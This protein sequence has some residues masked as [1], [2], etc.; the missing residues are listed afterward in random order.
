MAFLPPYEK[1]EARG[2]ARDARGLRR[3]GKQRKSSSIL[4]CCIGTSRVERC[5]ERPVAAEAL[6]GEATVL[7]DSYIKKVFP[8]WSRRD[9]QQLIR[10]CISD[11]SDASL[12]GIKQVRAI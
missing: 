5:S 11:I 4:V 3:S 10:V 8:D 12:T 1:P 6:T 7:K 9:F 2:Y